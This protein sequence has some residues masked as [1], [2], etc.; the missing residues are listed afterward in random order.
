VLAVAAANRLTA[1]WCAALDPAEG[2]VLSGA[3]AWPL[4]ALLASA[5]GGPARDE[6]E[7]AADISAADAQAAGLELLRTLSASASVSAALG[8][9]VR[10]GIPLD[11]GW[12]RP[13]PPGTVGE[14]RDPAAL[15]AWC[16]RH[17]GGQIDRLPVTVDASTLL[18][19]ATALAAKTRWRQPFNPAGPWLHRVTAGLGSVALLPGGVTRVV[20]E[21]DG[22]LDVELVTGAAEAGA[23]LAASLAAL[24]AARIRPGA[25]LTIGET[26]AGLVVT[27]QTHG[28]PL[29]DRVLLSVPP[30]ELAGRH[31]LTQRPDLFGLGAALDDERGHFPGLS[32]QPLAVSEAVQDVRAAFD[33]EGFEAAAVTA[34]AMRAGAAFV[35]GERPVRQI[36]VR[37]D[38]PFGFIARHRP[39]GLAIVAGWVA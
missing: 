16:A 33:A 34:V 35:S 23:V 18:V 9:W 1:R 6:L 38:R 30:F 5:A 22:D 21:G 15:D 7:R 31:D 36:E 25:E 20:V 17:T 3:C 8:L 13:L 11:D 29:E 39:S 27:E 19:L 14:L 2:F 12:V 32:P 26:A 28:H 24:E 10:Q 4:L 37:F